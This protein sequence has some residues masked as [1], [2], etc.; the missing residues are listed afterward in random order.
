[1]TQV[2][3]FSRLHSTG[4]PDHKYKLF[5]YCNGVDLHKYFFSVRVNMEQSTG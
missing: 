5:P 1:M 4:T 2:V 3:V